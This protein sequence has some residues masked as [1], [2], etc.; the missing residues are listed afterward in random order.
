MRPSATTTI[1]RRIEIVH[2]NT[3][4]IRFMRCSMP[5]G[6]QLHPGAS[7]PF[8]PN[9]AVLHRLRHAHLKPQRVR[10]SLLSS[11]A[12]LKLPTGEVPRQ[13]PPQQQPTPHVTWTCG[14]IAKQDGILLF[15]TALFRP[16]T[17]E[18]VL[19]V[20]APCNNSIIHLEQVPPFATSTHP[21]ASS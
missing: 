15:V 18:V 16:G 8:S 20:R 13:S 9:S 1:P 14:L 10:R 21:L 6:W 7:A 4:N 11:S 12:D 2:V 19:G 5:P 17:Q 3:F